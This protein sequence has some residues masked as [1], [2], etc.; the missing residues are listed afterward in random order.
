MM[1]MTNVYVV[2]T[3]RNLVVNLFCYSFI[4]LRCVGPVP[5]GPVPIGPVPIGP[6]PI[7]PV[8]VQYTLSLI[9]V[10]MKVLQNR[11]LVT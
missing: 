6:V 7:G 11:R 3:E 4:C 9:T 10:R 1:M 2:C 5:I 8:P